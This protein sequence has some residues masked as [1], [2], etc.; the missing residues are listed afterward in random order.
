MDVEGS[1]S[2]RRGSRRR[3]DEGNS[4]RKQQQQQETGWPVDRPQYQ[5]F[6]RPARLTDVHSVHKLELGRPTES[7][8]LL[9]TR[10]TGRSTGG[11]GRSTARST[12]KR[13]WAAIAGL[14]TYLYLKVVAIF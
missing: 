14:E 10:S 11:R 12:D 2:D 5:N 4:S 6:G 8:Q 3:K 9:G 1:S 13:V 7:T